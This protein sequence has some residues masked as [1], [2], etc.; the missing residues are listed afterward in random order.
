MLTQNRK[1]VYKT[2]LNWA[3]TNAISAEKCI[4]QEKGRKLSCPAPQ[5]GVIFWISVA[6]GWVLGK[7]YD[8]SKKKNSYWI[9]LINADLPYYCFI[10]KNNMKTLKSHVLSSQ[11]NWST[12]K[13]DEFENLFSKKWLILDCFRQLF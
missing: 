5:G 4:A 1:R 8:I 2:R 7:F 12:K 13:H 9:A 3:R 6:W 10:Q 11:K